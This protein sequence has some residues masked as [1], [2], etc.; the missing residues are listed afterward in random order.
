[1]PDLDSTSE[2]A[3]ARIDDG[4]R[5]AMAPVGILAGRG[6]VSEAVTNLNVAS[7]LGHLLHGEVLPSFPSYDDDGADALMELADAVTEGFTDPAHDQP[8]ADLCR[9]AAS[10]WR[11]CGLPVALDA[12]AAGREAPLTVLTFAALAVLYSG[13]GFDAARVAASGFEV[14]D[15]AALVAVVRDGFDADDVEGWLRRTIDRAE[16]FPAADDALA[17][18]LA[19]EAAPHARMILDEGITVALKANA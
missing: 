12:W 18:R 2:R 16:L 5:T 4:L 6:T 19:T 7:Y 15:D 13:R 14:R 3:R 1:M 9:D 8:L 11:T 17:G 10:R